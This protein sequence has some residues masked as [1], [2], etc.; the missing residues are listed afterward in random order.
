MSLHTFLIPPPIPPLVSTCRVASLQSAFQ[1]DIDDLLARDHDSRAHTPE[2]LS[3]YVDA[4]RRLDALQDELLRGGG[5]A[6]D[7]PILAEQLAE[8]ERALDISAPTGQRWASLPG[9][10]EGF[11]LDNAALSAK[12][13]KLSSSTPQRNSIIQMEPAEWSALGIKRLCAAN[14]CE[15]NGRYF[16]PSDTLD[17]LTSSKVWA[18]VQEAWLGNGGPHSGQKGLDLS[19]QA[20]CDRGR[21]AVK[22]ACVDDVLSTINVYITDQSSRKNAQMERVLPL[23]FNEQVMRMTN[24]LKDWLI[25]FLPHA[26]SKI[27][28]VHYGLVHPHDIERWKAMEGAANGVDKVDEL[29]IGLSR[30]LLAVPFAGKDVPSR[31]SEFAHPE[32]LIG[33][34]ILAYRYEGLRR[35]DLSTIVRHLKE[36]VSAEKGPMWERPTAVL[37]KRWVNGV[38]QRTAEELKDIELREPDEHTFHR[39]LELRRVACEK[40]EK[41]PLDKIHLD[42]NSQVTLLHTV[43]SGS[44]DVIV[45]Y[46]RAH[47]FPRVM[48]HQSFKLQASG[49]DLGSDMLFGTRLGFSGTPSN[50]LPMELRPCH[51]EPGSEAQIVRTSTD[52]TVMK[53]REIRH[54]TVESIINEVRTGGYNA[55]IDTGALITGYTNQEV[56][57]S[58]LSNGGLPHVDVAVFLNARDEKMVIE[59][60]GTIYPLSRCGVSLKKRFTF[61]DQVHTTGM[62]IKQALDATAACTLGKDMTLRDHAQGV[63]RMRGLGRGQTIVV[64]VVDEVRELILESI[65]QEPVRDGSSN[66]T[67][68]VDSVAAAAGVAVAASA[69]AAAVAAAA[70]AQEESS[71]DALDR[72]VELEGR[73]LQVFARTQAQ[74]LEDVLAWLLLN[75]MGSEHLQHMQVRNLPASPAFDGLLS[76]SMCLL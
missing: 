49:V 48:Q 39:V 26:M 33:L 64:L 72:E 45:H 24:L 63:Y 42:E 44:P 69:A 60:D 30:E 55:L 67:A 46:L 9:R 68:D 50:L 35:S 15:A 5:D 32:V 10:P 17:K 14:F 56:C 47:V 11:D 2:H 71:W 20:F 12:L 75:S 73:T 43:L 62:D 38:K 1:D 25:S 40:L 28:R 59:R 37:F 21:E 6:P 70:A 53:V 66:G 27:N 31:N 51:F 3:M 58:V 74:K 41:R 18:A 22:R 23:V 16:K 76:P 61:Y 19:A 65:G 8:A 34:T 4:T 7:A 52:P 57:E 29:N 36:K 54:W 13:A